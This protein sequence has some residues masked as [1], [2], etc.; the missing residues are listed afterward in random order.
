M[1]DLSRSFSGFVGFFLVGVSCVFWFSFFFFVVSMS[2]LI[3]LL[4]LK[5]HLESICLVSCS[6][7]LC[8]EILAERRIGIK[9]LSPRISMKN[10]SAFLRASG[11]F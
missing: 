8:V 4:L 6:C 11:C 1:G 3:S 7:C 9:L 2:L 5:H 10:M